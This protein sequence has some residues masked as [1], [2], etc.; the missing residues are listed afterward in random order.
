MHFLIGFFAVVFTIY[1]MVV[2][3]AIRYIILGLAAVAGIGIYLLIAADQRSSRQRQE[4]REANTLPIDANSLEFSS[5]LLRPGILMGEFEVS[6]N[7]RNTSQLTL[8]SFGFRGIASN[9]APGTTCVTIGDD[10]AICEAVVPT[11][12]MRSFTCRLVWRDLPKVENFKWT[13]EITWAKAVF[14]RF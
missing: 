12:Q 6:G 13:Y 7:V 2:S 3:P 14:Q 4:T 8:G 5:L 10:Q 9:C 11:S 1:L